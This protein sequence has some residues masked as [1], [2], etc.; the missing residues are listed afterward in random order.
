M[1]VF[2]QKLQQI[3]GGIRNSELKTME[4]LTTMDNQITVQNNCL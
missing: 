3:N 1:N 4:R 2:E